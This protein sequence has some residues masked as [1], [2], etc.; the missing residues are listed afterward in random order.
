MA[1]SGQWSGPFLRGI[2]QGTTWGSWGGS[3]RQLHFSLS[4]ASHCTPSPGPRW[5][6]QVLSDTH[7]VRNL[8]REGTPPRETLVDSL[9][10]IT[11]SCPEKLVVTCASP[12]ARSLAYSSRWPL[13]VTLVSILVTA[14]SFILDCVLRWWTMVE[15]MD[16]QLWPVNFWLWTLPKAN[17]MLNVKSFQRGKE[18]RQMHNPDCSQAEMRLTPRLNLKASTSRSHQP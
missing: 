16:T 3:H 15:Q 8:R 4:V 11:R 12:S 7:P 5:R 9:A 13:T 17:T 1:L 2:N 14:L 10:T 18:L 6:D